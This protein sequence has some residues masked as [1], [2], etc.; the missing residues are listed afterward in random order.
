MGLVT[1][2]EFRL[3][4]YYVCPSVL[5]DRLDGARIA[6]SMVATRMIER[7]VAWYRGWDQEQEEDATVQP[8]DDAVQDIYLKEMMAQEERKVAS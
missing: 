6:Y 3:R 7:Y 8:E 5:T 4:R 2:H 1:S